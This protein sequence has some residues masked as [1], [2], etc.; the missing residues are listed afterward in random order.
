MEDIERRLA[1]VLSSSVLPMDAVLRHVGAVSGKRLRPQLV[2]MSARLFGEINESTRRVALFVELLHTATLIHDD[3]VDG[4]D[5][6]RGQASVNSRW[7]SKTAVL[8]GDYL[9]S[10]AILL[11]SNPEDQL[12]LKEMLGTAMVMS[13]GELMQNRSQETEDR[14]Q[15][16][17]ALYLDI[18]E[19]KTAR[20]IRA[21]CVCGAMSVMGEETDDRRRKLEL[22][23][24][25]GLNMGLVFQMRDDI[26]DD[27]N[28]ED[29]ALAQSLLPKYLDKALKALEA[30]TPYAEDLDVLEEL[31]SLTVFFAKRDY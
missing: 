1:E 14:S 9:L 11:L 31:R 30:L 13:E 3:V 15:K 26:L 19:R 8:A 7:D 27:D 21:C 29:T 5:I 18:I 16:D 24:D 25:F 22:I 28:A 2:F 12:I 4:S 10:K 6:R 17:S 20:L 23:G